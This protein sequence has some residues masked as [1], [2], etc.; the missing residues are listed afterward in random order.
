[1]VWGEVFSRF[2]EESPVAVIVGAVMERVLSPKKIDAIF[3]RAA[4][5]QYERELLFSTVVALMSQVVCGVRPSVRAA[6]EAKKER[7]G[8]SLAALYDKLKGVEPAVNRAL[9]RQTAAE[10]AGIIRH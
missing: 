2:L 8:V 6:Y 3:T 10:M 5:I 7:I 4:R 1:M 9:V